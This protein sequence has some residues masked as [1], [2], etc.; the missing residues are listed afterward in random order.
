MKLNKGR[1]MEKSEHA[2]RIYKTLLGIEA[3]IKAHH[4]A[5]S[6][7]AAEHG[8]ELGFSDVIMRAAAP[9]NEPPNP[10]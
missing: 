3:A 4:E 2:E 10:E 6:A 9:K 7:A 1:K 5:L 8:K